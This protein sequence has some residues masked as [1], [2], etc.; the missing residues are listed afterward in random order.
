MD[1]VWIW[2][3]ATILLIIKQKSVRHHTQP[4][5]QKPT[6]VAIQTI[7]ENTPL[8]KMIPNSSKTPHYTLNPSK[9]IYTQLIIDPLV[10]YIYNTT[11]HSPQWSRERNLI[12][13]SYSGCIR[14]WCMLKGGGIGNRDSI[15]HLFVNG[16]TVIVTIQRYI[17]IYPE[18]YEKH[19]T[20]LTK[21]TL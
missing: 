15:N 1:Y 10:L 18:R 6:Q 14:Y 11:L 17:D 12:G 3:I 2:W 16:R 4:H 8:K 7:C 20:T 9:I 19:Y 21:E 5:I 13:L